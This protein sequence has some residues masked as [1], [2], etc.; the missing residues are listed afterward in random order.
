MKTS[1]QYDIQTNI[2]IIAND[3]DA[4]LPQLSLAAGPILLTVGGC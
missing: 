4:E 3:N 1:Q 2:R